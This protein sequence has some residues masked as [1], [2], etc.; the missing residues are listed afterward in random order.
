MEV[1]AAH[2]ACSSSCAYRG[3]KDS[4]RRNG[5]ECCWL[6]GRTRAGIEQGAERDVEPSRQ[7]EMDEEG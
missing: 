2:S 6:G 3:R 7:A 5:V 4:V 1:G